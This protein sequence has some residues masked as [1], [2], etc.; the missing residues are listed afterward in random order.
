MFIAATKQRPSQLRS[1]V[2]KR[3]LIVKGNLE[4]RTSERSGLIVLKGYKHATPNGVK[5]MSL[6]WETLCAIYKN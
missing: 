4:F 3:L 5:K 6:S 1:D 2:R